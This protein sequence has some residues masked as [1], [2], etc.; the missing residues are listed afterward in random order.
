MKVN[1]VRA[2]NQASQPASL[3]SLQVVTGATY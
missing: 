1:R 3:D 2:H